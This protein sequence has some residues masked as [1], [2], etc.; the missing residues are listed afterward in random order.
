[1]S[2][3]DQRLTLMLAALVTAGILILDAI[4][5]HTLGV[6]ATF[7]RAFYRLYQRWP[8]TTAVLLIWIGIVIGHL[9]PVKP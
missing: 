2:D 4:L 3:A 6:D 5:W 8:V 9:L 7:S 1:M